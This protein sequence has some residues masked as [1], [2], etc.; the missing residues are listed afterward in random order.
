MENIEEKKWLILCNT[1]IKYAGINKVHN[2]IY[3]Y[4]SESLIL[5]ELYEPSLSFRVCQEFQQEENFV[6]AKAYQ[7]QIT[8]TVKQLSIY[9]FFMKFIFLL[10]QKLKYKYNKY[11]KLNN[12]VFVKK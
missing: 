12:K 1:L 7:Q 6:Y 4:Y 8:V 2:I 5:Y 10:L 3:A 9:K 11:K